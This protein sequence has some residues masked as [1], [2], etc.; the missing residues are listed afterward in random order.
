MLKSIIIFILILWNL[1]EYIP[2]IPDP[3]PI[4]GVLFGMFCGLL[5]VGYMAIKANQVQRQPV[6]S[7]TS[8]RTSVSQQPRR[9]RKLSKY[10]LVAGRMALQGGA[11]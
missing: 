1:H 9:L 8:R 6:A 11:S 2:P 3:D 7:R 10:P 4:I 5:L